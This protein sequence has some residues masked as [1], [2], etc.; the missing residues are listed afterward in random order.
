MKMGHTVDLLKHRAREVLDDLG[1]QL[2]SRVGARTRARASSHRCAAPARIVVCSSARGCC[3]AAVLRACAQEMRLA[4][5]DQVMIDP[6]SLNDYPI[7]GQKVV[8]VKVTVL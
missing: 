7:A 8:K 3:P 5:N 6:L 2:V 1:A 4:E